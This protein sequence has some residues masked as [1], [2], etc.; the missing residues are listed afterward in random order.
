MPLICGALACAASVFGLAGLGANASAQC[1][2]YTVTTSGG[3]TIFPGVNDTGNHVDDGVTSGIPIPFPFNFYG[4]P[5]NTLNVSS[6]GVIQFTTAATTYINVCPQASQ[7]A[8]GPAIFC[9]WD[10]LYTVTTAAGQGIFT[11]TSGST[12]FRNFY[13]E[14]RTQFCCSTAAPIVHFEVVLHESGGFDIIYVNPT[15]DP[16]VAGNS[17]TIGT[18][19]ASGNIQA[20][21]CN[22]AALTNGEVV[23]FGCPPASAPRCSL[24]VS[25]NVV[26][27][28]DTALITSAI[29]EGSPA[30]PPYTVTVDASAANG[31]TMSLFDDG[32]A[33][34]HGD[35]VAG[36][37]I[38]SNHVT[39]GAGTPNGPALLTSIVTDSAATPESSSCSTVLTINTVALAGTGSATPATNVPLGGTT[40]LQ[41][42]VTPATGPGSTNIHVSA[43]LTGIGGSATQQFFDD[44]THGDVTAGDNHFTFNATIG[45]S[46]G[47]YTL[48]FTVT[49]AQSRSANGTIALGTYDPTSIW[50]EVNNGGSDTGDMPGTAQ[51]VNRTV[52]VAQ[53]RGTMGAASD[54]D[55]YQIHICDP[56]NFSATTEGGTTIDTQLW[57][58]SL[59]GHGIVMDDDSFGGTTLQSRLTN[60]FTAAL[61]AGDYLLAITGFNQD[62]NDDG[63]QLLFVNTI[64]NCTGGTVYRCEHGPDGPGGANA[65]SHWD[66]GSANTGAYTIYLTGVGGS[67]CGGAT[68]S[69]C[70][71][72]TCRVTSQADCTTGTWTAGGTCTG[73]TSCNGGHFCG[74]A[75]FNCDGDVGTDAD[76]NAFFACLSGTC[77]TLP[78]ISSADFNGDGDTGTDQDI[79]AF[80]RVLA[81]APC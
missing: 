21:N 60:Q 22:T 69:C 81:G 23:S 77:P 46:G 51:V 28:G 49:D 9:F 55:M 76:I 31:G 47:N 26:A 34:G 45:G 61:P 10:D 24:S 17:A 11:T 29:I 65:I 18:Q 73:P 70:T 74:S 67:T 3:G 40:L 68:G 39:V 2:T 75:D 16:R 6:N 42:N 59:D 56:A 50:D 1:S 64:A 27:A 78:C 36:D 63:N 30:S 35:A 38:Y 37:R 14:Y 19:D 33:G 15:G 66:T 79:D 53:I 54:A 52:P 72:N 13:I 8:F 57:L 12:P 62:A 32:P 4:T 71:N 43:D 5:Y 7:A 41:V 58:F 25:P 44:G 20:F 48:P 80:F